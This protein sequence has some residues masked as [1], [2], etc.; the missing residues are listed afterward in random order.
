M[1]VFGEDMIQLNDKKLNEIRKKVG[2]LFQGGALYD[3]MS[4][5]E[6]LEF[7]IRRTQM[8]N[9]KKEVQYLIEQALR[10]VGLLEA[11]DKMPAEL[12]G[13]MKKRIGLARAL[14][15]K[16]EIILYDEPTT[17]LDSVTSGE[18]SE[19][20]LKVQEEYNASSIIITHDMKCAKIT[21]NKIKILNEGRFIAEGTYNELSNSTEKDIKAYFL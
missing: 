16:P 9:D 8:S 13:G 3:S 11:I 20:I 19:L 6:N 18:I 15:L 12:S 5:R 17:G 10:S 7:P 1:K 4:V 14:I 2:Y 21:T